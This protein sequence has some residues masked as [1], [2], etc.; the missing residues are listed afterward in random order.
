ML[1][2]SQIV[3]AG[4]QFETKLYVSM[5]SNEIKPSFEGPGIKTDPSGNFAILS[6][7]AQGGFAEGQNETNKLIQLILKCPKQM[8][9]LPCFL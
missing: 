2:V 7:G 3:P 8:V 1:P 5:A 9:H 6:V 4:L